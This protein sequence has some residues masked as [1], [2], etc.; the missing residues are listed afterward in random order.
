MARVEEKL[1]GLVRAEISGPEPEKLLNA[2]LAEDLRLIRPESAD[3]WILRLGVYEGDLPRLEGLAERCGCELRILSR[4]GGSRTRKLL[5]RRL[6]LLL[7]AALLTALL[8]V[9][10]LFVWEIRPV[11]ADALSRGELL[12]ALEDC[13]LHSGCFWPSLDADALRDRMLLREPRLA[14]L[15]VNI[16]GSVAEVR[17]LQ[18]AEKPELVSEERAADLRAARAGLVRSISA[19]SGQVTVRPGQAV[20]AGELL[21]SGTV[22]SITAAP[23]QMRAQGEVWADTWYELTALCPLPQGKEYADLRSQS[24]IALKIGGKRINFYQNGG[25]TIDGCDKIVHEYILGI[26]GLFRLPLSIVREELRPYRTAEF[27]RDPGEETGQRLLAS[28]AEHIEGEI[29]FSSLSA[30]EADGMT[31]VTLRAQCRENI[32]KLVDIIP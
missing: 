23:R 21:V 31:V 8:F 14:W 16:R 5:C 20:T 3:R 1:R 22:D 4:S 19:R 30:A 11:G 15:A 27:S 9:S 12:R 13:G 7:T 10:S 24:R 25:K 18:R 29:V 28:L 6:G 2:C 32:A 26:K 17:L